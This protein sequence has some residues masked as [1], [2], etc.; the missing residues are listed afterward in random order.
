M[1]VRERERERGYAVN[2]F[3]HE[4]KRWSISLDLVLFLVSVHTEAEQ[5]LL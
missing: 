5:R 1:S 3:S 2:M 4:P